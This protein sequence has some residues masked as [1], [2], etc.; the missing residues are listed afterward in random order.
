MEIP[1]KS[2]FL[3]FL[4]PIYT[5]CI[6]RKAI[7]STMDHHHHHQEQGYNKKDNRL[8]SIKMTFID[9]TFIYP[10]PDPHGC[11]S[12]KYGEMP[13]RLL[14]QW[15]AGE[16]LEEKDANV[17]IIIKLYYLHFFNFCSFINWKLTIIEWIQNRLLKLDSHNDSTV[18]IVSWM[19]YNHLYHATHREQYP[20]ILLE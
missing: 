9:K 8:V 11:F 16:L 10:L 17:T 18:S 14:Y 2:S 1:N 3:Y 6:K 12:T 15:Y 5:F 20:W 13:E 7:L 4:H 19:G